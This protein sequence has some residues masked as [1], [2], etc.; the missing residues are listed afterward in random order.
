[1]K[2]SKVLEYVISITNK[3]RGLITKHNLKINKQINCVLNLNTT[4]ANY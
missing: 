1:M 3:S 4:L 2:Q